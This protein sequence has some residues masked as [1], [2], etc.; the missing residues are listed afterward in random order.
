VKSGEGSGGR[1]PS[2]HENNQ[3]I[4]F[5]PR[6]KLRRVSF[7]EGVNW[8]SGLKKISNVQKKTPLPAAY[9]KSVI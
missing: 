3:A 9:A 7:T 5:Q 4:L 1:S 6:G 8:N 2:V